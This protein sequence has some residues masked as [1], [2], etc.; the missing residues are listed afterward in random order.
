MFILLDL[1]VYASLFASIFLGVIYV[2]WV[3]AKPTPPS[4]STTPSQPTLKT[5]L[6]VSDSH[7]FLSVATSMDGLL[8]KR[9]KFGLW[10][11]YFFVADGKYIKY[12]KATKSITEKGL[13]P[14]IAIA[15]LETVTR[16][17]KGDIIT[18]TGDHKKFTLKADDEIDG[19]R[20]C[21]GLL[22]RKAQSC[23]KQ[24]ASVDQK[25]WAYAYLQNEKDLFRKFSKP[26]AHIVD[27]AA[28]IAQF[29]VR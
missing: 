3:S 13:K 27:N 26:N 19:K 2:R 14:L 16:K 11:N 24:T 21:E 9:G 23:G 15:N 12:R 7:K 29:R 10:R 25:T 4:S 22:E 8:K 20:W 6:R 5:Q 18:I 1:Y 28:L 17:G